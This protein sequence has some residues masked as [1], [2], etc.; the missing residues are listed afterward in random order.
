MSVARAVHLVQ[1]KYT[2]T[3]FLV[4]S[5]HCSELAQAVMHSLLHVTLSASTTMDASVVQIY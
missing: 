4:S 3:D 5:L 2:V 1:G